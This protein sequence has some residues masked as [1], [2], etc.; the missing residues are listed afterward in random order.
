[1]KDSAKYVT[2]EAPE[3]ATNCRR[4]S[5]RKTETRLQKEIHDH[6]LQQEIAEAA[7]PQTHHSTQWEHQE[8]Q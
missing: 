6:K 3:T 4:S 8:E 7:S 2:L 1:M 5:V